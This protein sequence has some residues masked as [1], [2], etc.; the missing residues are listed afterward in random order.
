MQAHHPAVEAPDA[1]A[2]AGAAGLVG[3]GP[4]AGSTI[5]QSANSSAANPPLD[6]I[7]T[8][9][10]S[11][12]P[13][14]SI[15]LQRSNDPEEPYPGDLGVGEVLTQYQDVLDQPQHIVPYSLD[16]YQHWQIF[17][18]VDG[19]IGPDG[20][21]IPIKTQVTDAQTQNATIVFDTGF[22]L[23][24]VSPWVPLAIYLDNF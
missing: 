3:L 18:D 12:S 21:P 9:N 14:I 1:N 22:S 8:S 2:A 13:Y 10:S 11:L 24:Q 23:P 15:L 6:R 16:D 20:N 17:L 5:R 7:F 19:L 4:S